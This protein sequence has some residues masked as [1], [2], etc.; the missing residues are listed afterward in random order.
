MIDV[1]FVGAGCAGLSLAWR[2]HD[3]DVVL[4]D[5]REEYGRDRTW[6]FWNV[7]PHPFEHLVTHRWSRW[8]VRDDRAWIERS[9]PG[10]EYQYLPSDAFY[11][12]AVDR[13]GDRIR[14]GVRALEIRQERGAVTVETDRGPLR[15]RVVFDSRPTKNIASPLLQHF[16]GWIVETEPHRFDPNVATLM[17][18]AVPQT[19]G[20]HFFYVLPLAHDRALVEATWFGDRV[21]EDDAYREALERYLGRA[22]YRVVHR[23][24]GVLPMS[25]DAIDVRT[26]ERVYRIGLAG[27][28]AKPSTGYAFQ[29]IQ[30]FSDVMAGALAK[31]EL[32]DPPLA[33][34]RHTLALDRIFLSYV[35]RHPEKTPAMLARMFDRL[36]P[37]VLV[38]FLSD[39]ASPTETLRAMAAMPLG[40]FTAETIRAARLWLR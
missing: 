40:P 32:P 19:H 2:L 11:R 25:T 38:R 12:A 33:R 31:E 39:Q 14:L 1:L 9:A 36:D 8:R 3:R 16:E 17:D 29:S 15:A 18:F 20:V 5:P 22:P 6:C 4:I 30:R 23:E 13:L 37:R 7:V 24:R 27:G 35:S 21:L 34:P 10:I 28:M 26:S